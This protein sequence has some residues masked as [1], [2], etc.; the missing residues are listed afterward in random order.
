MRK[1]KYGI[2]G[3]AVCILVVCNSGVLASAVGVVHCGM[4]AVGSV[5]VKTTRTYAHDESFPCEHGK[6]GSDYYKVYEVVTKEKCDS[7]S[8]SRESHCEDHVFSYC[9]GH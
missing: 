8:Y 4:C 9:G 7:C 3:L 6:E 2:A 5:Y 1:I